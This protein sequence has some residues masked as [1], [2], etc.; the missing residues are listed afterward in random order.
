[1]RVC[2]ENSGPLSY[3]TVIPGTRRRCFFSFSLLHMDRKYCLASLLS[4]RLGLFFIFGCSCTSS[5]NLEKGVNTPPLRSGANE[6]WQ[7]LRYRLNGAWIIQARESREVGHL[8][9]DIS[10]K[11]CELLQVL[12]WC[13]QNVAELRKRSNSVLL[14]TAA[15][16]KRLSSSSHK[17]LSN[18]MGSRICL[19]L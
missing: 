12:L 17:S 11:I 13:L 18:A 9:L 8:T 2:K 4:R 1:M 10:S 14:I 19:F 16:P 3:R 15:L 5:G 7:F 6:L